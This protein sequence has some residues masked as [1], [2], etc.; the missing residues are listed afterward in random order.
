MATMEALSVVTVIVMLNA[1]IVDS[2]KP[3]HA[4]FYAD[5]SM[6]GGCGYDDLHSGYGIANGALSSALFNNG[7]TCGACYKIVCDWRQDPQW[8]LPG[9]SIIITAT[10]LCP[11]NPALPSD[12]GGWCNLPLEHFDLSEQAFLQIAKYKSGIVP[13]QYKRVHCKK[14]GGIKFTING[15]NYFELVLISNVGGRG[16][17]IAVWIKGSGTGWQ[18][19]TRNWGANWMSNSYF[20]GQSLSFQLMSSSGKILTLYNVA[21]P[22]WQFGQTFV[23]SRQ[24]R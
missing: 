12:N 2:W 24:F 5:Q 16:D 13:I 10:N 22:N 9:T 17:L 21:P 1:S 23:S 11:A 4:T 7:A 6:G 19:M 8:C 14:N 3:G 15:F 20:N 18:Q